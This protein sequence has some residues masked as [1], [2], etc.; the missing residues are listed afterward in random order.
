MSVVVEVIRPSRSCTLL[1]LGVHAAAALS[2][3]LLQDALRQAWAGPVWGLLLLSLV[4]HF[5]RR[6]PRV[7]RLALQEEGGLCLDPGLPGERTVG[8]LPSSVVLE[9][10]LWLIW[11]EQG[12]SAAMMLCADQFLQEDWR[13]LQRWARLRGPARFGVEPEPGGEGFSSG[14][15]PA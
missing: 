11:R 10:V 14:R 7:R 12:R 15:D 4:W 2:F 1:I 13:Q 5:R 8:L 6:S 3:V 9:R